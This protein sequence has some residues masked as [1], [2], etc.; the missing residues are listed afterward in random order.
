MKRPELLLPIAK[1]LV[2]GSAHR[3]I[4]RTLDCAPSTVTRIAA[5]IGRHA[6]LFQAAALEQIGEIDEDVVFDHFETFVFSQD[7]RLGLGTPV[8]QRSWFTFSFDPAPH[9]RAGRRAARRAPPRHPL[10]EPIRRSVV[11]STCRVI[12]LLLRL[13]PGG[14]GL[15][16][17]DHP[18]Y[19]CA[20][21]FDGVEHRVYRN[22]PRR[23]PAHAA[24]A[25]RRGPGDVRGGRAAQA[26]A[27]HAGP[28]PARD[29]RL[30]AED[31]TP[32][33]SAW[34]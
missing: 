20:R 19:R 22:P 10:P 11:L 7:D 1:M 27:P 21:D 14:L 30:R 31:Q 32:S 17:D 28:P 6:L 12:R 23:D 15:V 5:R 24:A 25:A 26:A 16:S 3:Q 33:S 18:A 8:G 13:A 2:A 4:A 29:H 34:H 9:R